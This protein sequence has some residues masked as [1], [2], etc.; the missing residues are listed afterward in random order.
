MDMTTVALILAAGLSR[1]FGAEDKLLF[2]LGG[3]PMVAHALDLIRGHPGIAA[4]VL[5]ASTE[6][7]AD[8]A[9][10]HGARVVRVPPGT[11]Q[12]GSLRAGMAALCDL[13]AAVGVTR[14]LV[15]LG[16]MPFVTV[17]DI[18]RLLEASEQLGCACADLDGVPMP[19]AVFSPEAFDA[20][21]SLEGDRGAG[22]LL[23][24]FPQAARVPCDPGHLRDIDRK[25]D[26]GGTGSETAIP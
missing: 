7:V 17:P 2:P 25:D 9:V 6:A 15:M 24:A 5:V 13:G 23:R 12:S 1:R 16:D 18:D 3:R 10:A 21:A 20:L 8:L 14:L 19:P 22:A 26:L 4:T 11:P